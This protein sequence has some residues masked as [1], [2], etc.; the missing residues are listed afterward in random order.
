MTDITPEVLA[1]AIQLAQ[2]PTIKLVEV[3]PAADAP[4]VERSLAAVPHLSRESAQAAG[5]ALLNSGMPLAEVQKH[6]AAEGYPNFGVETRDAATITRHTIANHLAPAAPKPDDYRGID[7]A[8][9]GRTAGLEPGQIEEFDAGARQW[10]AAAGLGAADATNIVE[11]AID[12]ARETDRLSASDLERR[13]LDH[14]SKLAHFAARRN[15]SPED[16]IAKAKTVLAKGG[17]FANRLASSGALSS[18]F[19]VVE[20]ADAA[21]HATLATKLRTGT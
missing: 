6:L 5:Q 10:A 16:L 18:A 1:Q 17:A 11:M 9:N 2:T 7:Y 13:H 14:E 21:D 19:I 8:S 12:H 15:V 20:L 3:P 4:A